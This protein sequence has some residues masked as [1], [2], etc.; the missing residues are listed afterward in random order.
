MS[1]TR[2]PGPSAPPPARPEPPP[3]TREPTRR[4]FFAL[5]PDAG[6]RAAL[7]HATRKAVRSSGGRPVPEES[8]HVT[9][10]FLGSVPERRVAE[11]QAIAR[12]V[13]EAP[14]AGAP[15]LVSFDRLVHWTKPRILC[16]LDAEGSA[17]FEA[18][19]APR[20][21]ALAGAPALA[22][23]LKG[24][25]TARGFSPDLKPFHA[26]VTVARKVAH[27]PAAQPLRPVP[28]TFDAFALIES[29]T[30]PTGPVYSVIES[31]LLGKTENEH[32]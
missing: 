32:E 1:G 10:A 23:S 31:Y 26:H 12:R 25:T 4:L 3:E 6:Q 28:W 5:W 27:A 21:G 9:L 20:V 16:A 13:A 17:G 24:E 18:A 14:E 19:G 22:E 29:R 11:L 2:Q 8:L 30:E 7:V 15:M